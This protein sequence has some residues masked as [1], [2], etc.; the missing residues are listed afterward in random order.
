MARLR[1]NFRRNDVVEDRPDVLQAIDAVGADMMNNI[2]AFRSVRGCRSR[3][4]ALSL[5]ACATAWMRIAAG[6]E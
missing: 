5:R 4:T 3:N 1:G 6:Y 2:D